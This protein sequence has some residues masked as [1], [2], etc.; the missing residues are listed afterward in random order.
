MELS[1]FKKKKKN[2][3]V[4][5]YPLLKEKRESDNRGLLLVMGFSNVSA[6]KKHL[7]SF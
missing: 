2:T 7:G 6:H 3:F 4:Q 1:E 5:L